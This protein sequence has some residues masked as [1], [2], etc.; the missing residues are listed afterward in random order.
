MYIPSI[1]NTNVAYGPPSKPEPEPVASGPGA[2]EARPPVMRSRP[3][4]PVQEVKE[5]EPTSWRRQ[6]PIE[7]QTRVQVTSVH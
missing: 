5:E 3:R 2:E 7:P 6:P 1:K 4:P